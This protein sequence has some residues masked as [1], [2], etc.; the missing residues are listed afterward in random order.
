[1]TSQ[2]QTADVIQQSRPPLRKTAWQI[3]PGDVIEECGRYRGIVHAVRH[4]G[5]TSTVE[6]VD[7]TRFDLPPGGVLTVRA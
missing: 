4:E 3:L 6:L 1:M 2:Y 5:M 7:G